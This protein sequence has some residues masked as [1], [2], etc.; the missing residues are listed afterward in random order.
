[1]TEGRS[2]DAEVTESKSHPGEPTGQ[3]TEP[4]RII[5]GLGNLMGFDFL[6]CKFVLLCNPFIPSIYFPFQNENFGIRILEA[7]TSFMGL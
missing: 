2:T 5:P 1:M 3:N 4:Q 7:N 6:G